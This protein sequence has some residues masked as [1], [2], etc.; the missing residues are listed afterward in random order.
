MAG[1]GPKP[2]WFLAIVKGADR[3][4]A[5]GWAALPARPDVRLGCSAGVDVLMVH[6]LVLGGLRFSRPAKDPR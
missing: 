6:V 1:S 4:S 3:L 2:Q 5:V